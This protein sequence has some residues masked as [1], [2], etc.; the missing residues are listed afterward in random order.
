ML[1]ANSAKLVCAK[2]SLNCLVTEVS[3][4]RSVWS[5]KCLA[6][7]VSFSSEHTAFCRMCKSAP[8]TGCVSWMVAGSDAWPLCWLE[9]C[10]SQFRW[11]RG[12]NFVIPAGTIASR[13]AAGC[14]S[15]AVSGCI[16]WIVGQ[17]E[18]CVVD[19]HCGFVGGMLLNLC[20]PLL[21]NC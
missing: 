3:C 7:E 9:C 11:N 21:N 10:D 19:V 5:Q 6:M 2:G 16:A 12:C 18:C 13:T 20:A 1:S 4:Q 15:G 8:V 14:G 17:S